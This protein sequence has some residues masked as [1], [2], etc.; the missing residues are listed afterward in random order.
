MDRQPSE[1]QNKSIDERLLDACGFTFSVLVPNA[2]SFQE[3]GDYIAISA[4]SSG[5]EAGNDAQQSMTPF[6]DKR[7]L[8]MRIQI[9]VAVFDYLDPDDALLE[10]LTGGHNV[11][12]PNP[13][14][15]N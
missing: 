1:P 9:D 3:I 14:S 13:H 2:V 10:F 5:E 7:R 6:G 12:S 4:Q 8:V 11:Q 15:Q